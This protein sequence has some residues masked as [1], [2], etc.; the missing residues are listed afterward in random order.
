[1]FSVHNKPAEVKNEPFP[2][3]LDLCLRKTGPG[4][5]HDYRDAIVLENLRFQSVSR[6]HENEK[7]AISNFFRLKSVFEKNS[8]FVKD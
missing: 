8:V 7:P 3:I 4:K 6:P 1:M 2:L 5:S